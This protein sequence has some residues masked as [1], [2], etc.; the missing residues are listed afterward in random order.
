MRWLITFCLMLAPAARAQ[1]FSNTYEIIGSWNQ[2]MG[3]D[4]GQAMTDNAIEQSR[5]EGL[6]SEGER[7]VAGSNAKTTATVATLIYTPSPAR[8]RANIAAYAARSRAVDPQGA[9]AMEALFAS[10]DI[11]GQLE[12][13][14]RPLGLSRTNVAD[15]YAL[16][17]VVA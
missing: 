14:L 17:W 16:W 5:Q 11:M 7:T 15:A 2:H 6:E 1:D 8:T 3:V 13:G 4:F 9:A 12:A 10:T